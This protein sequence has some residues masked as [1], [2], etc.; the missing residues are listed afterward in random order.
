MHI[1]DLSERTYNVHPADSFTYRSV[2]WLGAAVPRKG[3]TSLEIVAQLGRM[4]QK[5]QLPDQ[6]RG[7]H[8][9]ELCL[10]EKSGSAIPLERGEALDKGEFYVE[11]GATRYV[12][13]NMVLHYITRH[14]YKLPDEVEEAVRNWRG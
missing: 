5:N 3:K 10:A 7:L 8:T 2:G 6:F 12:L 11:D 14:G 1:P 4:Q 13:P 9:C